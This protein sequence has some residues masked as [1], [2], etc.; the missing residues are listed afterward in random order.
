MMYDVKQFKL[1]DGEE[2]I[3]DVVDW[4]EDGE[5]EIVVR[6]AMKIALVVSPN[7]LESYYTFKPWVQYIESDDEYIIINSDHIIGTSNPNKYL[8]YQF[9]SALEE[10]HFMAIDRKKAFEKQQL[11]QLKN[12]QKT[13][14]AIVNLAKKDH[15]DSA[16]NTVSN[17][18]RFPNG[19]DILH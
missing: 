16:E 17:V 19:D 14:E 8:L 15:L 2:V 10:M 13:A 11:E 18:I 1:S 5:K 12:L 7:N 6:N 3:C 9:K 4:P